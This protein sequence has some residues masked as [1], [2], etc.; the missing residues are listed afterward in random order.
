MDPVSIPLARLRAICDPFTCPPW[1]KARGV[2]SKRV[3]GCLAAKTFEPAP[4]AHDASGIAH[5]RRIAWLMQEGWFDPIEVEVPIPGL[6]GPI[7]WNIQDGNHRTYA[8][9]LRG[10][11][12]ISALI[13]G[14]LNYAEEL[15]GIRL[16]EDAD[17]CL[18]A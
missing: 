14:S 7:L 17:A 9:V 18:A 13:S 1:P 3:L 16:L 8:A 12:A 4:I 11:E 6:G 2:S 5:C 10:D 15:F